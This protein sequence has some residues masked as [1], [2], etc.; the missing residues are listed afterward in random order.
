MTD[1]RLKPRLKDKDA[2]TRFM[3]VEE[4]GSAKT[5]A[6]PARELLARAG[7]THRDP[8]ARTGE[9]AR[10]HEA[11]T[12]AMSVA[13]AGTLGA[14]TVV[15]RRLA[16]GERSRD[17]LQTARIEV[18]QRPPECVTVALASPTSAA[19]AAAPKRRWR[20][21][22]VLSAGALIAAL[23]LGARV[24]VTAREAPAATRVSA[25]Q[26]ARSGSTTAPAN[27]TSQDSTPRAP[28][29]E[30]TVT[31]TRDAGAP[32]PDEVASIAAAV[33]QLAAADY[34]AALATY[35]QLAR[36]HP[37]DRAFALV[38]QVLEHKLRTR[39]SSDTA[40]PEAGCSR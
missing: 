16:A 35:Q 11:P 14:P 37:E 25:A 6:M 26:P 15:R 31:S 3:R 4:L 7:F 12:R 32:E 33:D 18:T 36:R 40:G 8:D 2:S 28:A 20:R 38:A 21:R 13:T 30:L 1:R 23:A 22:T 9:D 29:F 10:Q 34:T 24:V 27:A 5:V 39:C 19:N 17:A